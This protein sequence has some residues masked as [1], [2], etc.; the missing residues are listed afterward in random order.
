MS[1]DHQKF[2]KQRM[3]AWTRPEGRNVRIKY[4]MKDIVALFVFLIAVSDYEYLF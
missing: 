2:F 1:K 3:Y 4:T